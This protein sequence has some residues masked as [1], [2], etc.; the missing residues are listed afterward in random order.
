MAGPKIQ[1]EGGI[2]ATNMPPTKRSKGHRLVVQSHE[3]SYMVASYHRHFAKYS[4][5]KCKGPQLIPNLIWK[6]VYAE[7]L[8]QFLESLFQEESLKDHLHD[9]LS[10]LRTGTSNDDE[11]NGA[12]P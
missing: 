4:E 2:D 11:P 9:T 1:P 6:Q 8:A 7:F 10:E 5:G 3:L 12:R